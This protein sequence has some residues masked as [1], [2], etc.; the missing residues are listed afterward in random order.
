MDYNCTLLEADFSITYSNGHIVVQVPNGCTPKEAEI[1]VR[2]TLGNFV[3]QS[4]C[5]GYL[6][7]VDKG[8]GSW[9]YTLIWSKRR[10][11]EV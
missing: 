10:S 9:I 5:S 6:M 4:E 8:T 3:P 2:K 7:K 11:V 1:W